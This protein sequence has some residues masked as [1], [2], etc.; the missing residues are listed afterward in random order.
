MKFVKFA[1]SHALPEAGVEWDV[2]AQILE[3][4]IKGGE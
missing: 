2:V 3:C 4:G 1:I